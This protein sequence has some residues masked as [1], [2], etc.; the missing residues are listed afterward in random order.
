MDA[1]YRAQA[2]HLREALK[3]LSADAEGPT[4]RLLMQCIEAYERETALLAQIETLRS[5]NSRLKEQVRK[6]RGAA[7]NKESSM[8]SRLRD[9]LRE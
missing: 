5:E 2:D 9:A 4:E 8:S 3:R 7:T 6:L 1:V